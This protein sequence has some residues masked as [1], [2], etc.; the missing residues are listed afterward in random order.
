M[1]H[2]REE[3]ALGPCRRFCGLTSR[4]QFLFR[5]DARGDVAAHAHQSDDLALGIAQRNFRCEQMQLGAIVIDGPLFAIQQRL[6]RFDDRAFVVV[7]LLSD[8]AREK[9]EVRLAEHL[10][11]GGTHHATAHVVREQE[12]GLGVLDVDRIRQ[13]VHQRVQDLGFIGELRAARTAYA[14]QT[15]QKRGRGDRQ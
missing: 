1:T 13:A 12:A 8:I 6:A 5:F 3:F 4:A 7:E 10:F 9:V 2:V 15:T 11:R 14:S